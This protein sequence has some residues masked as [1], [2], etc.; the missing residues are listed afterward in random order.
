[1]RREAGVGMGKSKGWTGAT[2]VGEGVD[3]WA[4]R[5]AAAS[6]RKMQIPT[7]VGALFGGEHLCELV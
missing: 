7:V 6:F 3:D 2:A 4:G 5:G 1:M